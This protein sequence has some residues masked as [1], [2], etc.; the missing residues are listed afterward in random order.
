[1][2]NTVINRVKCK[3]FMTVE[4]ETIRGQIQRLVDSRT[5]ETSEVHRRLLH[6]LAEKVIS[7]DADRLK[8]YTIGL[9]AFGKPETY[10]PKLDSIV[11]LQVSRLRQ[12]LTAYYQEEANGADSVLVSLPKGAFRLTFEPIAHAET[13][14]PPRFGSRAKS[15]ALISALVLATTWAAISTVWLVHERRE[16]APIAERWNPEL[17][18]LWNPFL[19]S[20]RALLV[21]LG[22]PMFIRFPAFGFFRD[23]KANDW[24]ELESSDRVKGVRRALGDRDIA[25]SYHFTG[26]GEAGAAFEVAQLLSTRKREILLAPSN[27]LSWQQIASDDVVFVGPPKFNRQLQ[28]AALTRDIVIEPG[29]VR[30]L[31]PQAGEP[32]F[33]PDRIVAGKQSE[34]E[35]HAVITRTPGLSGVGELLVIAGNGSPDTFAAAEWLTQSWRARE[36]AHHLRT[37]SGEIPRHFQVVLKVSFKQGVPVQSAYLFHHVLKP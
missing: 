26:T 28:T 36:L 21:C 1:V 13:A 9:E 12:K 14:R 23:P 33:L 16:S 6:Y 34:G 32:A 10:D 20:R 25:P 3:K 8:E 29:G 11:R 5:F 4:P 22:T 7:G 15:A 35:T 37:P 18:A 27:L 17:E 19:Q 30:N 24:E 31:K 2:S